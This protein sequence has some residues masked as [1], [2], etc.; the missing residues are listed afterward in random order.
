MATGCR[1]GRAVIVCDGRPA[2]PRHRCRLVRQEPTRTSR[3]PGPL[4]QAGS[5]GGRGCRGNR[6]GRSSRRIAEGTRRPPGACWSSACEVV[7]VAAIDQIGGSRMIGGS[8]LDDHFPRGAGFA[9][10]GAAGQLQQTPAAL[11]SGPA[12]SGHATG[13]R[14]PA[15]RQ[16]TRA[17][18]PLVSIW[19][20]HQHI[21]FAAAGKKKPSFVG[22]PQ[23]QASGC[24]RP[25]GV[26]RSKRSRT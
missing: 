7:F 17:V 20:R 23:E 13:H 26:S 8:R 6:R 10:A 4:G 1:R 9:T 15:P 16:V 24:P 5:G 19:V 12:E 25:L 18:D 3:S 2:T 11:F 22:L 21:G 14:P